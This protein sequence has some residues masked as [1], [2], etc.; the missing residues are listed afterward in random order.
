VD[1]SRS[2]AASDHDAWC[3][4]YLA[5]VQSDEWPLARDPLSSSSPVGSLVGLP[6]VDSFDPWDNERWIDAWDEYVSDGG[7]FDARSKETAHA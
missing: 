6:A 1:Y 4:E 2:F 3:K 5:T 7:P